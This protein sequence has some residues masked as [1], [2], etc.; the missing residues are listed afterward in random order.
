MKEV[1]KLKALD[2]EQIRQKYEDH[3]IGKDLLYARS[4]VQIYGKSIRVTKRDGRTTIITED[5]NPNR[6]NVEI[7]NAM[8]T[9]VIDLS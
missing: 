1:E 4:L 9:K 5:I 6:I 3:L 7:E 2:Q 8:I